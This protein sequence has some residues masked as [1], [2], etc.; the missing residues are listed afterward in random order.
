MG[1]GGRSWVLPGP[2]D[3]VRPWRAAVVVSASTNVPSA[4]A[5]DAWT[6]PSSAYHTCVT[7]RE[8]AA[9]VD[10]CAMTHA[11]SMLLRGQPWTTP[12]A[13]RVE[14]KRGMYMS[15]GTP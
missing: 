10:T 12:H 6:W 11:N 4:S 2:V 3:R 15:D 14:R 8:S 13:S 9:M 1:V 5:D 7:G